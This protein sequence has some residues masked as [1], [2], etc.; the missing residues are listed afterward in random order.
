MTDDDN[1]SGW[2]ATT[3]RELRAA[4]WEPG[5]TVPTDGWADAL[6]A[7]DGLEMHDAARA[8]LAEFGG[9][10]VRQQGPG[11]NMARMPFRLDPTA[12]THDGEFFE[13]F[14]ELVGEPVYPIG[15]CDNRNFYLGITPGG[16]VY[17]GMEQLQLLAD[18]AH[19]ALNN[20]VEGVADHEPFWF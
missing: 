10:D 1:G 12:A 15:E 8:F 13:L 4:G 9:L 7:S 17:L 11:T 14:S 18:D 6:L 20:L 16:S 5:R 2:S 19:T 3:E